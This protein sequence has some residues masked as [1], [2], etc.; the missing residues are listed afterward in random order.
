MD[1]MVCSRWHAWF[2]RRVCVHEVLER[3]GAAH[4]RRTLDDAPQARSQE[5]PLWMLDA[6]TCEPVR[7]VESPVASAPLMR[8]AG[9]HGEDEIAFNCAAQTAH[10]TSIRPASDANM[11]RSRSDRGENR[12]A[13]HGAQHHHT[14][15]TVSLD[16]G[17][18]RTPRGTTLRWTSAA[19][20]SNVIERGNEP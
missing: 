14:T 15:R 17:D 19:A 11:R 5:P 13:R 12:G 18:Q 7:G 16:T 6:A 4:A 9:M 3:Q 20:F 10:T 2:G 1:A 8:L